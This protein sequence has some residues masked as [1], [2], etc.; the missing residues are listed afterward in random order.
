MSTV[1][2]DLPAPSGLLARARRF[3]AGLGAEEESPAGT[4]RA[5]WLFSLP[6]LI[7]L[8]L[9]FVVPFVYAIVYSFTDKQL[10]TPLPTEFVGLDNYTRIFSADGG[11]YAGSILRTFLFALPVTFVQT[12]VALGLAMLANQKLRG[13]NVFRSIYFLP[14]TTV[15]TVAT[16]AWVALLD[17]DNGLIGKVVHWVTFGAVDSVDFF[18]NKWLVLP[19]TILIIGVWQGAGF[20]MIILLAGLQDI[21]PE[22]YEAARID[23]AGPLGQ[24]RYV[25]L[26]GLRNKLLLVGTLTFILAMRVFDQIWAIPTLRG[27][28]RD[29]TRTMMVDVVQQGSQG[30]I[31]RASAMSVVFFLVVVAITFLQRTFLKERRS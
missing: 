18:G 9:F 29:G 27:G 2:T 31:G 4:N 28:P 16:F 21:S 25:T 23:G 3:V 24:F 22:L 19:V 17:R 30:A 6:A 12:A 7:L 26:P 11:N 13:R 10:N 1:T 5:G 14:T 20:Q 15:M 8:T